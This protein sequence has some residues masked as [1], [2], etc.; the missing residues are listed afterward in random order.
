M[1]GFVFLGVVLAIGVVIVSAPC[2][3]P[4]LDRTIERLEAKR[5]QMLRR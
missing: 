2:A 3:L 5:D 4:W 1:N